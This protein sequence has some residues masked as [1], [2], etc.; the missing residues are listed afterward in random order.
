MRYSWDAQEY[1]KL[2]SAGH[3]A[4]S[5]NGNSTANGRIEWLLLFLVVAL[6]L[7]STTYESP[8]A[9]ATAECWCNCRITYNPLH[10]I[11]LPANPSSSR[12]LK[13]TRPGH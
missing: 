2:E 10:Y 9:T 13:K 5:R 4:S 1:L 7:F 6:L 12:G 8:K 3:F 11:P